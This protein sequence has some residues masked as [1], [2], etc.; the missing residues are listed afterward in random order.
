MT[1]SRIKIAS[2]PP[3]CPTTSARKTTAAINKKPMPCLND[4]IQRP[5]FGKNATSF[6][7][8]D[9]TRKGEDSPSPI[10]P[11]VRS[12]VATLACTASPLTPATSGPMHGAPTTAAS[13]PIPKEPI[14]SLRLATLVSAPTRR[15][16]S[17]KTPIKLRPNKKNTADSTKT[18]PGLCS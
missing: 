1:T 12:P 14:T 3:C 2:T 9:N 16:P 7:K 10:I 5:G 13:T 11:K 18:K 17:S 15:P 6:G 4:S 8:T